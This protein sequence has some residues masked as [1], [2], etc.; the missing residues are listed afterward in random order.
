MRQG[1][2][3]LALMGTVPAAA[4]A[5]EASEEAVPGIPPDMADVQEPAPP[6]YVDPQTDV[7]DD[8]Y[9]IVGVGLGGFNTYDGSDKMRLIPVVGAMGRIERFNFRIR[10]TSLAV[11]LIRDKPGTHLRFR[12]GPSIRYSSNRTG[13]IGDPVVE[14]LGK[15]KSGIEGGFTYGISYRRIFHPY[16]S[17]S[18]GG[19]VRWDLSGRHGGMTLSTGV[20]YTT[21][22]SPAQVL[23]IQAGMSFA[24]DDYA[25][26]NYS[27][28]PEG[29]AA[30]GLPVYKAK[31]GLRELTLGAFTA[32]DLSGDFRDGGFA[33]GVGVQYGRLQGSAAETP[34][35][36]IR[37]SADQW[38]AGGGIAYSF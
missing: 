12:L 6:P 2:Y 9:V 38:V 14:Q 5:Q 31:G 36:S 3:A 1:V 4:A 21:P 19:S 25:D 16:D 11:D 18:F 28:T 37:G 27:V 34:I 23:G 8:N 24:D 13:N 22:L 26:Y 30:S 17:L 33:I 20:S 29:S 35:T 32:R 10:G 15:L 7:F